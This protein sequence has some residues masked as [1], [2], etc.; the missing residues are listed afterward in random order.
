M[1][2]LTWYQLM[3]ERPGFI[4]DAAQ[5]A[6]ISVL[7]ELWRQLVDFKAKRNHFLGRSLLSPDVP[8]GLYFWGGVGRGKSFLMDVFYDCVPYQRKRRMHFHNFMAEV[9]HEMKLLA[10][11]KDPLMALSNNIAKSTRLLCFDEFH[12]SDIADAMILGRLLQGMF[13]QGVVMIIT[14]NYSPEGLYPNGLQRQKFLPVIALL[15]RELRVLHV[16]GGKDYRLREMTQ[17][18]LF[19]VP[20]DEASELCMKDLFEHLSPV[21][22]LNEQEIEIQGRKIALNKLSYGVVWFNFC[23]IC[24]GTRDQTD[25]LEIANQF[26]T[27]LISHLP[28]LTSD[29]SAAVQRF[30]WLIDVFYDN[31]VKLVLSSACELGE[32]EKL[33]AMNIEIS[34]TLSRL[35][36]MQ[37]KSYLALPHQSESITLN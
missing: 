22:Q 2:P 18:S 12:V 26:H 27:V 25:Y 1:S 17:E 13:D 34:R 20:D 11:E 30:I 33:S 36:E 23:E 15:K 29:H 24:G 3:R 8:K 37:T 6:A 19:M 31:R 9:H 4:Y 14:S 21:A 32:L 35:R 10:G 28:K 16:E 5:E 7:D